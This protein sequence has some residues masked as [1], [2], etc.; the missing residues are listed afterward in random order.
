[1]WTRDVD[2]YLREVFPSV[3][4]WCVPHLWQAIQPLREA[5]A[6]EGDLGPAAEIGV[7]HGK[8]FIGLVKTL[9]SASGNAAI[10]VFDLQR[11]NLDRAGEGDLAAFRANLA[12][13]GV[14]E[15]AVSIR[16]ADSMTLG[17]AE[18]EALRPEGGG[19]SLFSVDGCHLAAHTVND[20]RVAMALTRPQGLIFV[21]DYY[22]PSWPGVQEGVAKLYLMDAPRFVPLVY[23]CNKLILC[24]VSYHAPYFRALRE[25]LPAR[26]PKTQIKAVQRF[27]Q[28]TLTVAP[29]L[30]E[31]RYLA[32]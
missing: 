27:G 2:A 31:P 4:G 28:P 9:G 12:R 25:F 3:E 10:D 23:L 1:M 32:L 26:F 30:G 18:I 17:P 21:D 13:A 7:Y 29:V 6:R 15:E 19:Y 11:F 14:A 20:I 22:N 8:F 16:R 24:H 5:M